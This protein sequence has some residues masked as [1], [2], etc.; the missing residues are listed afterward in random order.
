MTMSRKLFI[1]GTGTDIGKTYVAALIVKK[2]HEAGW[3]AAYYKA[4][5]SGNERL[6]NGSILP[7]DA[8]FV[9]RVSGIDQALTDMCPFVYEPAV[10]PHLAAQMSNRPFH[11]Q[12]VL[13][14]L[15]DLCERYDCVTMEGAGGIL[16][17]FSVDETPLYLADIIKACDMG[18]L[19]V[20]DAGLGTINDVGLT[21]AYLRANDIPLHGVV[22][23]RFIAGNLLHEDNRHMCE[24]V[25]DAPVIATVPQDADT[26]DIAAH[27]LIALYH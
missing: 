21:A 13:D 4:A 9:R 11:L 1:I 19:L 22:L 25:A 5:M 8:D 26:I 3:D 18:C 2:L 27:D 7:G 20:A 23:N 17:P 14:Q 12:T 15:H 10:S 16:C 6:P 24:L